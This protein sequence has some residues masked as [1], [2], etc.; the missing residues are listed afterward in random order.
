M[1]NRN[2]YINAINNRSWMPSTSLTSYEN[3][4]ALE[5]SLHFT[6]NADPTTIPKYEIKITPTP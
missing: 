4:P 2:N 3:I 5:Q 6:L 1:Q